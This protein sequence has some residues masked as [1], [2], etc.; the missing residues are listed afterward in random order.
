MADARILK[1][2][3]GSNTD[4]MLND[5]KAKLGASTGIETFC[6]S[7]AIA[8]TITDIAKTKNKKLF[9]QNED[10][11]LQEILIPGIN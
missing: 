4:N 11:S 3:V 2:D 7:L 1:F 5:V 8:D 9:V 6:R 10:G